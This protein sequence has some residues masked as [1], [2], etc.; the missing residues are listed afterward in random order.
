MNGTINFDIAKDKDLKD[1]CSWITNH[2]HLDLALSFNGRF[3]EVAFQPKEDYNA[4]E[5]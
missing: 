3:I 4:K 2:Q 1:M 5:D